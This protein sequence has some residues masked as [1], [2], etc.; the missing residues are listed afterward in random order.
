MRARDGA[1]LYRVDGASG[2]TSVARDGDLPAVTIRTAG[3]E[4]P[5]ASAPAP[6]AQQ[7]PSAPQ[8]ARAIR[9]GCEGAVSALVSAEARR[10]LPGRCLV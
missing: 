2:T 6:T 3:D 9:V 4:R 8:P 10:M 1:V 7:V 5:A